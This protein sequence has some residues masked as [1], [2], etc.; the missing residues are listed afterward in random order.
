MDPKQDAHARSDPRPQESISASTF[1]RT[2]YLRTLQALDSPSDHLQSK[3]VCSRRTSSTGRYVHRLAC[4][5]LP[6]RSSSFLHTRLQTELLVVQDRSLPSCPPPCR[7]FEAGP[8]QKGRAMP[9]ATVSI[10]HD[11]VAEGSGIDDP[12]PSGK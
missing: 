4:P 6:T 11:A 9:A 12:S 1:G 5:F 8:H 10:V 2:T 7:L 3:R